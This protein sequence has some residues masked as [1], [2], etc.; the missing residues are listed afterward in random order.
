MKNSFS[1]G[2]VLVERNSFACNI[3]TNRDAVIHVYKNGKAKGK[4]GRVF[5]LWGNK[6]VAFPFG[7]SAF[8]GLSWNFL[9]KKNGEEQD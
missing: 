7:G 6:P 8:K 2:D 3:E 5:E 9:D 1:I 4:S